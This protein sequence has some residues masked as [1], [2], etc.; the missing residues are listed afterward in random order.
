MSLAIERGERIC[1]LGRNGTGKSTLLRVLAGEITPDTGALRR[2]VGLRVGWLPQEVP[3]AVAGTVHEVVASALGELGGWL[4]EYSAA[5]GSDLA[6]MGAL[7]HLIEAA[8]GWDV[9]SRIERV[10]ARLELPAQ[11]QFTALSGGMQRRV[12]LG[13]ALVAEPDLLLLDEPTNHLDIAAIEW[14][15]GMLGAWR[16]ALL[17]TTH[18]RRFMQSLATR[19]LEIDR[20]ALT[21][22]PGDYANYLRRRAERDSAEALENARFDKRLAEEEVW[23]R[24]GIKARRTRNEGRVRRLEA[25]RGERAQRREQQASARIEV[26][27]AAQSGRRVGEARNVTFGYGDKVLI[28]DFSVLIERGDRIGILG[29]NGVGKTTLLRLL[30]GDIAP[31]HG[32]IIAGTNLA[33]AYFDQ[34]RAKLDDSVRV[35]DAI[36]DGSDFVTVGEQRRHVIGYLQDFLFSPASAQALVHTLS[37]GER[38][39]LL[40]ARLF[41]QPSNLLVM[42]EPTNDLDVETL[43]LLEERLLQYTG[44]LLLISHDRVFIDNVVTATLAFDGAGNIS[45]NVGGYSDWL[46][47]RMAPAKLPESG[48]A[49]SVNRTVTPRLA[50]A[51]APAGAVPAVPAAQPATVRRLKFAEQKE[52][53]QL[54][55]RIEAEEARIAAL[56]ARLAAPELYRQDPAAAVVLRV[57]LTEREASL[58]TLYDRWAALDG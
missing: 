39:R 2:D 8:G 17:F 23:I 50:Q 29:A 33:T 53:A 16:G 40:L 43:E 57:E 42:D 20:G 48:R 7:Q 13:R 31:Q 47:R 15:E 44:T 45:E 22:W 21:S 52:L 28:R 11:A 51:A 36:A 30:L 6:R 24:Q 19:I 56:Q 49:S 5:D 46:A 35:R 37:G 9:E 12:L 55:A 26:Q 32:T 58:A 10:L 34:H 14:L 54:P 38:A 41:A 4:A 25:M 3:A 27:T 18:D 1:L